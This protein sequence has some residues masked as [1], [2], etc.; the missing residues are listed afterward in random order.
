MI[1]LQASG[2]NPQIVNLLF[3]GGMVV[4]FYFFMI[5]PQQKKQKDQKAFADNLQQGDVVVTTGGI[6]GKIVAT[7]NQ[8]V[9]IEI[10]RGVKM[11]V[12]KM[13]ISYELS[14]AI[15]DKDTAKK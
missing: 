4:V 10:D 2:I 6:H 3:I 1:L 14:K 11:K 13:A 12:E 15:Q 5:R 9:I 8:A 7:E